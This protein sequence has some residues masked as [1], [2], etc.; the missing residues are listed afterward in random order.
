MRLFGLVGKPLTHSFSKSWFSEKFEREQIEDAVYENF[1]LDSITKLPKLIGS[2]PHLRGLNITIPY[3]EAVL[4]YLTGSTRV[5][6]EIGACNCIKIED[7]NLIGHNTDIIG[8]EL[9]LS[10]HL[11]SHHTK[12]LILGTGG[13]AKAVAYVLKKLNIAYAFVSRSAN[14]DLQYHNLDKEII[15]SHHL[16]IN[17][18][19]LGMYPDISNYPAIDFNLIGEKHLL[20]DLI[21]NPAKTTFLKLG[22]ARGAS[23]IDGYR[24]LVL[25]AEESWKVWNS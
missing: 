17:T 22:E 19:P 23:V 20:Y 4:P 15:E 18:T 1:E 8:F 7:Q 5:V 24:M 12:A 6:Q 14:A 10:P 13:A 9:S 11:K 16:I 3:K 2:L 25:Q 21:Y